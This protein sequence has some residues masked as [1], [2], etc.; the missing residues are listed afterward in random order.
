MNT[1][2]IIDIY[3]ESVADGSKEFTIDLEASNIVLDG[4][5]MHIHSTRSEAGFT[6]KV[7]LIEVLEPYDTRETGLFYSTREGGDV[8]YDYVGAANVEGYDFIKVYTTA[9]P[10]NELRFGLGED[11]VYMNSGNIID[12]FGNVVED[13]ATEFT[14]DLVASGI[15]LDGD[16]MH[17]HSTKSEDGFE[18]SV[19]GLEILPRIDIKEGGKTTYNKIG[20]DVNYDY[21]GAVNVAGYSAVKIETTATVANE[22]RFGLGEDA[23]YMNTGNIIDIYGNVVEDGATE[24]T[25][26]LVASGI[27]LDGDFMHIHSTRSEAGF[28]MEVTPLSV[29]VVGSYGYLLAQYVG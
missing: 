20:G 4:D 12:I 13:G 1:G 27:V 5:F 10:A 25:I 8:D 24:F 11:A 21:V 2:N 28:E 14:I 17:I 6:M 3:G 23:V 18:I 16:F 29:N 26:D 15:V 7:T 19:Y 9:T 22:L